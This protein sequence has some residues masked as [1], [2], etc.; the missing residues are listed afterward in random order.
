MSKVLAY[1]AAV[2]FAAAPVL[3]T[4]GIL[5]VSD[6]VDGVKNPQLF[7][8]FYEDAVR[9]AYK[10]PKATYALWDHY[11]RGEPTF[12]DLRKYKVIIWFTSTSGEAPASDPLRGNITLSKSEQNSLAAFLSQTP[13][14][15]TVML[16][17]MYIAW[18]CIADADHERQI[19]KPLFS[20]YLKLNYPK[21]NFTNW[22]KVEDD[23]KL[24][25]A[26]NPIVQNNYTINWRHHK[27]FPDQLEAAPGGTAAAWW[28]DLDARRHHRGVIYAEGRKP[29][30]TPQDIYKIVLFSCPFENILHDTKRAEVMRNFLDWAGGRPFGENA[31]EPASLGRVKALF[32]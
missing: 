4:H 14:T 13:G 15:T 26:S 31:V 2:A 12:E 29:G 22:I 10:D 8:S 16:S 9:D 18:N 24:V 30:G 5:L 23:W 6:Q 7:D 20:D 21:D 3:A 19:Y 27:N 1:A 11:A 28:Q 25:G 17:G 32:H